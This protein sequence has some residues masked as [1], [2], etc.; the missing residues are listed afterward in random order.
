MCSR[1]CSPPSCPAPTAACAPELRAG[2]R[3]PCPEEIASWAELPAGAAALAAAGATEIVPGAAAEFYA[4]HVGRRQPRRQ[5]HRERRRRAAPHDRPGHRER[6]RQRARGARRRARP[7][8][9]ASLERIL[10]EA[11]PAGTEVELEVERGRAGRLRSRPTRCS[12]SRATR[13]AAS[14]AALRC[15]C[16]PGGSIP[17]LAALAAA[18]HPDGADRLRARLRRHPRAGRELPPREPRARR[19]RGARALR[20]ARRRSRRRQG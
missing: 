10:R 16:A 9:A 4:A 5:R 19:A 7:A 12:G 1:R 3:Q 18:R 15:S 11:A 8:I 14:R 6:A 17:I 2:V 13:S 20:G